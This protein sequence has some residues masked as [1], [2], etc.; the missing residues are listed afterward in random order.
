MKRT[1]GFT[2]I[3]ISIVMAI[4]ALLLS[5]AMISL[6]RV[7]S[8][9]YVDS[10]VETLLSDIKLQQTNAMNGRLDQGGLPAAYGIH[11][12]TTSYTVFAGDAYDE[13]DAS[14]FTISLQGSA[15]FS[16]VTFPNNEIVFERGSGEIAGFVEGSNTIT[17]QDLG[18]GIQTYIEL[19]ALGVFTTIQQ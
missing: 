18:S 19:N 13:F 1:Y 11:F 16:S 12:E 2:L 5:L 8:N 7:Q 17:V 9:T 6:T 15:E 14:N 4:T 10:S 3:E